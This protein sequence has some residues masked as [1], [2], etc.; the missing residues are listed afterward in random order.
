[1]KKIISYLLIVVLVTGS[2]SFQTESNVQASSTK[3]I[4][5]TLTPSY[6][7]VKLKWSK[8]KGV[9]YYKIYKVKVDKK[10]VTSQDTIKKKKYKFLKKISGTKK[11]YTDK[12]VKVNQ[13]YAYYIEGYAKKKGKYVLRYTSFST[14]Y[15]SAFVGLKRPNIYRY[16]EDDP[17]NTANQVFFHIG[18]GNGI[19]PQKYLVYR[20]AS[21]ESKYKKIKLKQY[22]NENEDLSLYRDGTV[23]PNITY[24]YKVQSYYKTKKKKYT[25]KYSKIYTITPCNEKALFKVESLTAPGTNVQEFVLKLTGDFANGTSIFYYEEDRLEDTYYCRDSSD[26]A[27]S[28][29]VTISEYSNDNKTWHSLKGTSVSTK[30][31]ETL[32]LKFKLSKDP[33]DTSPNYVFGG[34]TG[35]A[36]FIEMDSPD[37]DGP[38]GGSSLARFDLIEGTGYINEY[39]D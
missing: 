5:L 19:K 36:S 10:S 6:T 16:Y 13:E 1:M 2:F 25:S 11:S 9:S 30:S 20:K 24:K 14:M 23:K 12:K 27:H 17:T 34:N 32:Y 39:T 31:D 8:K 28:Y 33:E 22:Q 38:N 29:V 35:S 37:Y 7:K 3:Y 21:N 26:F 15:T 18:Y 4:S